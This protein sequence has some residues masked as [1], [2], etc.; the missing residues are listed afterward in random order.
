MDRRALDQGAS[1]ATAIAEAGVE[2]LLIGQDLAKP[3]SPEARAGL[4]ATTQPLLRSAGV[5]RLRLRDRSGTIVFDAAHPD[6]GRL[7]DHDEDVGKAGRGQTVRKLTQINRDQI[8]AR[9]PVGARAVEVYLPVHVAGA[10]HQVLGVLELYIP[11]APIGRSVAAS[12]RDMVVLMAAALT[13]LWMLLSAISWSVTRRLRRTA[14]ANEQLALHDTLTGLPNRIL[15][16]DRAAHALGA[17][18][19]AGTGVAIAVID[20]DRFK[21]VNDTLG[22]HNGDALLQHAANTLVRTL[23]PGD[24]VAR[25]GGDEFGLVLPDLEPHRAEDILKRVTS[26]LAL[27]VDLEGVPVSTQAS[28]GVAF[29]PTDAT[30]VIELLQ[31]ADLAM[32]AAK[33]SRAG[34]VAYAP[35]LDHYSPARLAL[36]GQLRR[37]IVSGELRLHYQP[38]LEL[39]TGRIPGVEAL[40]RWE[41]PTRGLLLPAEFLDIA[42]STG[43]I[44]PLTD[45]V[46]DHALE[47]LRAW[48]NNSLRLRLAINISARSLRDDTLPDKIFGQLAAHNI[49]AQQLE[50]EITETAVIADPARAATMLRRLREAG[51]RIS[52]DDFGQGYTSLAHL[53]RLPLTELKIDRSFVTAMLASEQDRTII[54]SVIDLGHD[55]GLDVVAEGAETTEVLDALTTLGC[56]IAQG[57]VITPP[58]PATQIQGW[59]AERTRQLT[60]PRRPG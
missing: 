60:T 30:G 45:W 3:L 28:I 1:E 10:Q 52:L 58:L 34:I 59:I 48:Q 57:Y 14:A 16:A 32:Y 55:L 51:V 6:A 46:I 56:D 41:H 47:Q 27:D 42:E 12:E 38:K 9:G 37:A 35:A 54:R 20:L 7:P 33:E 31:Y 40:V 21:E 4:I 23:R 11:Y 17:A 29:W 26:A 43:L 8:D 53:G 18:R 25:L 2:P 13:A 50:V 22:H 39:R 44:T 5:L 24:T 36:V 19:R 49:E 15:F